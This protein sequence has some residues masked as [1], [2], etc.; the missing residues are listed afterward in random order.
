MRDKNGEA[1][2]GVREG[3]TD[4][5]TNLVVT[6]TN[7]SKAHVYVPPSC[8]ASHISGLRVVQMKTVIR[9]DDTVH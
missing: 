5:L 9:A 4:I 8:S 1:N 2:K 3:D 7:S 6:W